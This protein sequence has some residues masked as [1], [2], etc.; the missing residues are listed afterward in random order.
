[1]YIMPYICKIC[2]TEPT[3]HSFKRVEERN[4]ITV[5]YT[6]P[7][8]ATQ[9]GTD[10][11][12]EHYSGIM[13]DLGGKPWIWIFD[14][15]GF[16]AKHALE[17]KT[18]IELTKLIVSKYSTSLKK[19]VIINPTWHIRG[20]IKIIWPFINENVRN[21]IKIKEPNAKEPTVINPDN[22]NTS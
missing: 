7:A 4:G 6:C 5:F 1:M 3:A 13:N 16:D 18:A 8:Q 21:I 11:I 12:I 2:Q 15:A 22:F 10:G 20:I 14:S 17:V 19:I 9:T